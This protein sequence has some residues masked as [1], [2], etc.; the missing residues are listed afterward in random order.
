MG[1]AVGGGGEA[2]ERNGRIRGGAVIVTSS[3]N[4]QMVTRNVF[5]DIRAALSDFGYKGDYLELEPELTPPPL[6]LEQFSAYFL[7]CICR[8]EAKKWVTC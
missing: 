4:P 8:S 5:V 2:L 7:G 1:L 3:A 6:I